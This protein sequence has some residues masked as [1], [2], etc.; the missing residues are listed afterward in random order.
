MRNAF[1]I[2]DQV[3][4][5][6]KTDYRCRVDDMYLYYKHCF[7]EMM[8]FKNIK[9]D[10]QLFLYI[11]TDIKFRKSLNIVSFASIERARRKVQHDCKELAVDRVVK[12]RYNATTEY[13]D[14]NN[15]INS[16]F[17]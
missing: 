12:T 11:F 4:F 14:F 9:F 8:N 10:N 17:F 6:L 1:K 13:I 3:K 2:Y 7:L 16:T 15:G 5:I